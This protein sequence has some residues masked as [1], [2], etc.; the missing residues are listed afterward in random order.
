[1]YLGHIIL[2][3]GI[4]AHWANDTPPI[5]L[6]DSTSSPKVKTEEGEGIGACSL[7]RST[8]GVKG[9]LELRDGTKKINKQFNYSHRP[10]QTKQQVG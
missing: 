10:V 8:L 2:P 5:S 1:M 7:V 4:M 9:M 3:N 6:M